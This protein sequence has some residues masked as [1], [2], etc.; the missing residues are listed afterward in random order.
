M[1]ELDALAKRYHAYVRSDGRGFRRRARIMQSMWRQAQGFPIGVRTQST[2]E[3]L[4]GSWLQMP[5]AKETL[6]NYLTD[7]IRRVVRNEVEDEHK[8]RGKLFK[9]PRIYNDL[10]SSQPLC[11]NLFGELQQNLDLASQALSAMTSGRVRSVA[12][13]DFE[14]SP[15]RGEIKYTDD[16]SA[17]DVFIE[18]RDPRG[19]RGFIGIE[20]KYHENLRD[21]PAP[22]RKRY[23][24]VADAMGCFKKDRRPTLRSQPLQQIWRDHLLAGAIRARDAFDDGFFAFLYPIGNTCCL[25]AIDDYRQ[26]LASTD[27]FEA[28]QLESLCKHIASHTEAGWIRDF[29]DRYLSFQKLGGV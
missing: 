18:Y 23:D 7:T 13:I 26:S 24:E 21:Q 9:S 2:G 20:V 25:R 10:L 16:K 11:F 27:T 28:W 17:F 29:I 5:W 3:T 19:R 1:T 15:G 8:S 14:Y 12:S 6:S 4:H 22:H